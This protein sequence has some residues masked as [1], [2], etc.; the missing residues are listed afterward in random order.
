MNI[1]IFGATGLLGSNLVKR[2]TSNGFS[3]KTFVR[4]DFNNLQSSIKKKFHNWHPDIIIN[5]IAI[6]NLQKCEDDY[7]LAYE[8]NV[9]IAKKLALIAQKH[10]SYFIHISTDHFYNDTKIRHT[11][12]DDII[13]LN[14]YA[15]TKYEAEKEAL[16][17]Y[18]KALVVRTNII[19]FRNNKIDSFFE[20]LIRSLKNQDSISLYT[21]FYTSP[22]DINSL[23]S[24]LIECFKK[25]LSGIYNITSSEVIDK[26]NFGMK[27]ANK[28]G[29]PTENINKSM[30]QVDTNPGIERAL[31]LGLDTLKIENILN[32][33]MPKIDKI[34]NNLYIEYM[35]SK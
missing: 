17:T 33:K 23:S 1:A 24:L 7:N 29:Y 11:E 8:T 9:L 21:N 26:Y 4:D 35:E 3:I 16:N 12:K 18:S 20:W 5:A 19:G 30:I 28:F 15:K 27:V 22:I 2:Y 25:K 6:V 13:L 14:N 32:I 10:N 31:T 34:V